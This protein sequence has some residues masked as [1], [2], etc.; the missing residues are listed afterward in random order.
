MEDIDWGDEVNYSKTALILV[1]I[2]GLTIGI[3][4]DRGITFLLGT[5]AEGGEFAGT[6]V[7]EGSNTLFEL[8][9]TWATNY[10]SK[11]PGIDI[12]VGG[13][14]SSVGYK[15]L[16]DGVIDIAD[17][18][19]L[20]KAEELAYAESR[21]VTFVI[22]KVVIDGIVIIVHP[23][24]DIWNISLTILRGIYNGSITNWSD[25]N[26]TCSRAGNPITVYSRD[27][28]SGTFAYFQEHVMNNDDYAPTVN[29]LG[30]N[31]A[32]VAAVSAD[33]N[34][35][36]YV[37]AAYAE[38]GGVR[39]VKVNNPDTG[40]PVDPTIDNIKNFVYP[41]SRYLY[42]VTNGEPTGYVAA[43]LD[44]CIGPEGQAIATEVGYVS[45]Y[46]FVGA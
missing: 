28:S 1:L 32:I 41:I 11:N 30:G 6:I 21:G 39:T 3:G 40:E 4:I 43:Y 15:Q 20:P 5:N 24:N 26:A 16:A 33:E 13:A 36:G 23:S 42:M 31:S 34:A 2:V 8:Q 27:P 9:Q 19:R 10:M 12:I 29:Q 45:C 17:A 46:E 14:G 25:V 22:H 7:I 44:W 38:A 35:I 18:S 37:G